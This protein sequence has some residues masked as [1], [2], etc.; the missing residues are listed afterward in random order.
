MPS[1]TNISKASTS[2]TSISK[3]SSFY[4]NIQDTKMSWD[5]FSVTW[6]EMILTWD[7]YGTII[8]YTNISKPS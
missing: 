6:D 3:P 4:T 1:Y 7:D 8:S 5:S 2:F